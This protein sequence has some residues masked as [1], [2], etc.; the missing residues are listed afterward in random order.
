MT[1]DPFF[2]RKITSVRLLSEFAASRGVDMKALLAG[3]GILHE[4]LDDHTISVSAKQELRVIAN[5][6]GLLPVVPAL[7]V[8]VGLRYHFTAFGALGFAMASSP[9]LRA[10][11]ET[12]LRY[13]SLTFALSTFHARDRGDLTEVMV[14]ADHLP[15]EIRAFVLERDVAAMIRVQRD[16]LPV[17]GLVKGVDFPFSCP[18]HAGRYQELLSIEPRFDA[19]HCVLKIDRQAILAP[20]PYANAIAHRAAQDQCRQLISTDE[21]GQDLDQLIQDYLMRSFPRMP[22]M[23]MAARN[24]H[25]TSRTLRRRLRQKNVSFTNIRDRVRQAVAKE[26][27][28]T[29][30]QSIAEISGQL[31]F[32]GTTSFINAFKRWTGKTPLSYRKDN[33]P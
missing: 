22:D 14:T 27:L 3:T 28:L 17:S 25:M 24:F 31:G 9:N 33:W 19:P 8:E 18:R 16:L 2:E 15:D 11:L 13:F 20:L 4:S 32:A 26:L 21:I 1:T 30:T 10:V 6:L 7:G 5:L 23:E 29:T 12:T